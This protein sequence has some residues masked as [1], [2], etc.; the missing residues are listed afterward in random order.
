L[1][2][3][4]GIVLAAVAIMGIILNR[5]SSNPS[6][7]FIDST[8]EIDSG[9]SA[10]SDLQKDKPAPDFELTSLDGSSIN[11]SDFRG[12]PVLINYWATWCPPCVEELPLIEEQYKKFSPG[13]VV[14]AINAG[15]EPE[16]VKNYVDKKGFTFPVLLDPDWNAEAL[17]G[18]MAYPTSVFIDENGI[19][20]A[21]YVGGMSSE[22]LDDYLRII[23][24]SE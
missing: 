8:R 21:R 17:F 7:V 16:T 23:G 5:S 3:A 2:A 9:E 12:H 13:L 24:V 6:A 18:I 22:T 11:L 20:R 4:A 15:E 10:S 19:I 1:M 14:L